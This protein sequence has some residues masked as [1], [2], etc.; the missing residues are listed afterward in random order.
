MPG[1]KFQCVYLLRYVNSL[2]EFL[3]SAVIHAYAFAVLKWN[4]DLVILNLC[5]LYT[6]SWE[7]FI[8]EAMSCIF[9]SL[10]ED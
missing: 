6:V 3:C 2:E 7:F 9:S 1:K 5:K 10:E 4:S 8:Y